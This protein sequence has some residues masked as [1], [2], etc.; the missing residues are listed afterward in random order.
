MG[1]VEGEVGL[2]DVEFEEVLLAGEMEGSGLTVRARTLGQ[3][4]GEVLGAESLVGES[5]LESA[6][7]E[8]AAVVFDQGEDLLDVMVGVDSL[9]LKGLEVGFGTPAESEERHHLLLATPL[10]LLGEEFLQMLRQFH[11][12]VAFE[13]AGVIGD[14]TVLMIDQKAVRPDLEKDGLG[15]VTPGNGVPVG[16]EGD[17]GPR[18]DR[19]VE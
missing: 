12:R 15:G 3:E 4:I 14:G 9:L 1:V 5:V 16:V 10:S 2:R 17:A 13:G 8:I 6:D 7:G 19:G 11:V 18:V